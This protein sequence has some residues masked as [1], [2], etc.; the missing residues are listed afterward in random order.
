MSLSE[1]IRTMLADRA[2]TDPDAA[3]LLESFSDAHETLRERSLESPLNAKSGIYSQN[4]D[5]ECKWRFCDN[6]QTGLG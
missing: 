6:N 5:G 2:A 1:E 3:R 4:R